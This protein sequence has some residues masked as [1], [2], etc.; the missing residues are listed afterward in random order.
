MAEETIFTIGYGK[1]L[2]RIVQETPYNPLI[3][4]AI[5]DVVNP[6][7]LTSGIISGDLTVAAGGNFKQGQT[8]YNTGVGFWLG[9]INGS[10]KL[11][12]GNSDGDYLVWDGGALTITGDLKIKSLKAYRITNDIYHS[13]DTAEQTGLV[14]W[15]TL[16]EFTL[17]TDWV[18]QTT[19]RV[20]YN[21]YVSTGNSTCYAQLFKNDVAFGTLSTRNT[22]TGSITI[23]EDLV[24]DPSDKIQIKARYGDE[25]DVAQ[26]NVQW[27]RILGTHLPSSLTVTTTV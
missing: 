7:L 4:N 25:G 21:H 24:F 17:G 6:T 20:T 27:F 10:A 26:S 18:N 15:T 3:Y 1:N 16:K 12:I 9:D 5:N 19:I 11:S 13:D 8:G 14:P 23:T 2:Y 22:T